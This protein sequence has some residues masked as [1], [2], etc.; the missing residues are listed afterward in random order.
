M[1]NIHY[2][3]RYSTPENTITNNTLQL[4]SRIYDYSPTQA[5][6]LLSQITD[7]ELEIGIEINQQEKSNTSV[8]DGV[9]LQRSFKVL[10]ETKVKR[11]PNLEQLLKHASNF[12]DEARKLLILLSKKNVSYKKEQE[13][14]KEI[15]K[16]YPDV[17]F[18]CI[19]FEEL[20][21]IV[22]DL[23]KDYEYEIQPVIED[24][25]KYCN[26]VDLFDQSKYLLR[27][28][29]CNKSLELNE[30]YGI[31]YHPSDRGYTKHRYIGLYAMKKVHSILEIDGVFDVNIK[32]G[33]ITKDF[34]EGNKSDKYDDKIKNII[35]DARVLL[36]HKIN[37]GHRFFCGSL[38]KTDYR[39]S[40]K[41]GIQG[42]RFVNLKEEI[43]EFES[44]SNVAKKLNGMEW[45]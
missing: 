23:F 3:Q 31:Y 22:G 32:N 44:G 10:I 36:G 29:P 28:V 30:K 41:W 27:I 42:A 21:H 5:S 1:S 17:T 37:T 16:D 45:E 13:F 9:I 7:E 43:G 34:I 26:D 20:C 18:I 4:F 11:T 40:S 33:S 24:Y 35:E 15:A 39:K 25:I 6:K 8:P 2:F 19:T 12:D 38:H 14:S